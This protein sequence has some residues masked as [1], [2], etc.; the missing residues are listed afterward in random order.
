MN[1]DPHTDETSS[2][3]EAKKAARRLRGGE[4]TGV[5][6]L[7][8]GKGLIIILRSGSEDCNDYHGIVL[9]SMPGKVLAQLLLFIFSHQS[10]QSKKET[11][12]N[13]NNM[14]IFLWFY[15]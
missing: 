3:N 12:K 7:L 11:N 8:T 1:A 2:S 9:L 10:G 14:G 13:L 15:C 6:F 5:T 4:T